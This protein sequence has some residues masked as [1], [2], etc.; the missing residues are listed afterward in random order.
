MN[1]SDHPHIASDNP[2]ISLDGPAICDRIV[3]WYDIR[4]S[5]T[6]C[7]ILQCPSIVIWHPK[8]VGASTFAPPPKGWKRD[9]QSYEPHRAS[10]NVPQNPSQW[11]GIQ[12]NIQTPTSMLDQRASGLL[13]TAIDIVR[14]EITGS[15]R[16]KLGVSIIPRGQSYWRLW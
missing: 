3:R 14:E 15:F 13:S 6:S 1:N 2:N 9:D 7:Y 12:H 11:V 16:D 5:Q 8:H 4:P 10:I